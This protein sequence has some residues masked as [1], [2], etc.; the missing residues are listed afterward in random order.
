M[1]MHW[2]PRSP[3]V[4]KAMIAIH[5]MGLQDQV[6][7]VRTVVAPTRV[8]EELMD[9]NPL[10]KLPTLVLDDGSP[11]YDSRVICEYLDTRHDR[12]RLFPADWS[13]RLIA[14]RY[15]ALGDGLMDLSLLWLIERQRG[16][17]MQSDPLVIAFGRKV[18]RVLERLERDIKV[19]TQR[20]FDIGHLTVGCALSYLDF[21]FAN[22]GW[23]NGHPALAAWH[24]TFVERPSVKANPVVDDS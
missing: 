18:E 15:Q 2:S 4:R 22:L 14:L 17:G 23:R 11:I 5:E 12:V 9:D 6:A 1:K 8:H 10:S 20:P 3:F 24:A 7:C 19:L 13:E 21:R 16:E